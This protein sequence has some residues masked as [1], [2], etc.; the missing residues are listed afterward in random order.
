LARYWVEAMGMEWMVDQPAPGERM[1]EGE[2]YLLL[3]PDRMHVLP[4]RQ[5]RDS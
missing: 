5:L 3:S 4:D 2:V 1:F